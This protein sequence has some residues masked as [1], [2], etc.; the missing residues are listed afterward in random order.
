MM[1]SISGSS[2]QK[3]NTA[4][5]LQAARVLNTQQQSNRDFKEVTFKPGTQSH[6]LFQVSNSQ[7]IKVTNPDIGLQHNHFPSF[8]IRETVQTTKTTH[9]EAELENEP[10]GPETE[11]INGGPEVKEEEN[12]SLATL[13]SASRS[14]LYTTVSSAS[15]T[16]APTT[17][18]AVTAPAVRNTLRTEMF[19]PTFPLSSTPQPSALPELSGEK[20]LQSGVSSTSQDDR[21]QPGVETGFQF[22]PS[23][24]AERE[25]STHQSSTISSTL[26]T[27]LPSFSASPSSSPSSLSTPTT[28]QRFYGTE[29]KPDL[30]MKAA[31]EIPPLAL[32]LNMLPCPY[33][34]PLT[35]GTFYFE[36]VENPGP[37]E[38]KHYIR[39]SCNT[40]Y[41]LVHG[42]AHNYC[43]QG[44]TWN[45]STPVCLGRSCCCFGKTVIHLRMQMLNILGT[46]LA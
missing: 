29:N 41:T 26:S 37:G 30:W 45:G 38:Y 42:D 5:S 39:Y 4:Q 32:S 1:S 40:G 28:D 27:P 14:H 16:I 3:P 33:P 44:G 21:T 22:H 10:E 17:L 25:I 8:K 9:H 19:S 36:N 35:H 46:P 18:T 31:A 2:V 24:S 13:T 23:S 43:Q 7:R 20:E 12:V 15:S 34:P 6:T 11:S